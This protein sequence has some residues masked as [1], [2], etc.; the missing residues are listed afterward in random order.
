MDTRQ[1]QEHCRLDSESHRLM[2]HAINELGFSARGHARV[3]RLARTIADLAGK[4]S[5][6]AASVAESIRYR[7]VTRE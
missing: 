6:D 7:G 5:V 2:E 1:I 4:D 3:L